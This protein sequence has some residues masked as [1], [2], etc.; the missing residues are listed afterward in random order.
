MVL[1]TGKKLKIL[2][3]HSQMKKVVFEE[4][5]MCGLSLKLN[6]CFWDLRDAFIFSQKK[7]ATIELKE[8]SEKEINKK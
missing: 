7:L 8:H 2:F 3:L 1:E 4:L 5:K 6:V